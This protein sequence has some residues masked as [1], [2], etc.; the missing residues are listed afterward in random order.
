MSNTS[1]KPVIVVSKCLGFASCRYNGAMIQDDF[2]SSLKAYVEFITVCPEVEIGLGVPRDPI[3]IVRQGEMKTL[4][5][6]ATGKD[7]TKSMLSFTKGFLDSLGDVDGFILKF[8]SPS[9]G[10]GNV[11]I[12]PNADAQSPIEKGMGF[13]GES[14]MNLFSRL[15]V[16]DEGRLKNFRI[17]DHFLIKLY[18]S[19]RFRQ[20]RRNI[21]M[22]S[23]ID[24]HS[25]NKLLFMAYSQSKTNLLGKIT[26]NH[27]R[28]SSE[29]VLQLYFETMT[30]LLA[31]PARISSI[32]N[33]LEHAFGGV[34]SQLS[35]KEKRFFLSSVQN[36][37]EQKIPLSV[38]LNLL[39]SWALRFET[40]YLL[41]QTFLEPYPLV[42]MDISDSGKGRDL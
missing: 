24:F 35:S 14:V 34:S 40:E 17:R 29:E 15:A 33:T 5:Q 19:A 10:I 36:Y 22:R 42:L 4:I 30:D 39:L 20:I 2:V 31:K 26:A 8:K 18:S 23:L 27:E 21:S 37:K 9:C 13:F 38:P 11:K 32:I 28:K 6:P 7:V 16:E 25:R 41:M 3:R 12:F 1:I